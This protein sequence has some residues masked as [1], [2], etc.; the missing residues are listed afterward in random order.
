MCTNIMC[1]HSVSHQQLDIDE[2]EGE[3]CEH[4]CENTN[5]SFKCNCTLGY[6]LNMDGL[7]CDGKNAGKFF[8][9]G[10]SLTL[11]QILNLLQLIY[12]C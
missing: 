6:V 7:T 12:Y 9:W 11:H 1:A 4:I 5:G 8:A 3:P 2:C 10:N